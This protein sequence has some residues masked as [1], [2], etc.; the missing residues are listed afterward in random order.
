M[1]IV[2]PTPSPPGVDGLCP[3]IVDSVMIV[4]EIVSMATS[5][6]TGAASL[7]RI[8]S[9]SPSSRPALSRATVSPWKTPWVFWGVPL[10]PVVG[11]V[12]VARNR[13]A[14]PAGTSASATSVVALPMSTPAMRVM[15]R[16]SCCSR[17]AAQRAGLTRCP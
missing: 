4:S 6:I 16:I 14:A 1:R 2:V 11:I 9:S 15:A 3:I 7:M 8:R 13:G 17:R 10:M 12:A 5:P